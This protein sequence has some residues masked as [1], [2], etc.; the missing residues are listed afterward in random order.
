MS[1]NTIFYRL[2][3]CLS[4]I[5]VSIVVAIWFSTFHPADSQQ[6]HIYCPQ[7]AP[8]L[9]AG[10]RIKVYN[11]NVQFM[12]GKNYVFFYDLPNSMGPDERPSS[13]DIETTLNGLASLIKQQN[14]D[15]IL[16]QE[17]DDGAKRTGYADQLAQLLAL[18]PAEYACHASSFYWK[19]SYLPHPRI[20][21]AV[22]TKLSI[23]SK[24][25]ISSATRIQL[26]LIPQDPISQLFNFKRA[27]F[28]VR[29]P[30]K[31]STELAVLNT[32]LSAFS[33]G[34]D[35]LNKQVTQINQRL[36]S[37]NQAKKPW[38][39]AGDFN[40]LPPNSYA[41][42]ATEQQH[43]YETSSA[44]TTLYQQHLAIP[45]LEATQSNER[46]RWFTYFPNATHI[47]QPDRTIDYLFHSSQLTM[48]D[49]FVEQQHSLTLSDH[50]PL[51]ASFTLP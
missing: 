34:T 14:P 26:S 19:A 24:Y 32:H 16:L 5:L 49:A 39:L 10:Q 36:T 38:L 37:L 42:L 17:V 33:K 41:T 15:I 1:L 35:T 20:M 27:L 48:H 23:I 9:S 8:T 3:F 51:I 13:N 28:D 45:K 21:G 40:L 12:A 44:I 4:F 7:N 47:N 30:V 50:M 25:Q 31:D 22:G 29:L 43:Y 18:L 2:L 11:Q 6:E 46:H